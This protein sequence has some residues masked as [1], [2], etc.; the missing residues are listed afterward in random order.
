M[1]GFVV[2]AGFGVTYL[3][4]N[5]GYFSGPNE[6]GSTSFGNGTNM[7]P[8]GTNPKGVP[9]Y[10]YTDPNPLS[11]AVGANVNDPSVYGVSEARFDRHLKNGVAKQ[12]NVFFEKSFAKSWFASA[13][14]SAS[15]SRNLS[16]RNEV[17]QGMQNVPTSLLS[18]WRQ[19]YIAS[20]GTL[21]PMTQLIRN[22]LQPANGPLKP[23]TGAIGQ[24]TIQRYVAYLPYPYLFGGRIDN[25]LGFADYHAMQLRLSHAFAS[26]FQM[27]LNYTWSKELDYTSTAT[28]D[29]QGFNSGGTANAPDILNL[30]N[31]RKYGSA[32]SPHRFT[33]V[34]V[35]E[36]PFGPGKALAPS[37]KMLQHVIGNWQLGS[38]ITMQSGMPIVVSGAS[39][40]ALVGGPNRIPGVPIE[41][42][43]N[44]QKWYDGV[45]QVQLPCGR[46]ITPTKN[47]F[48]KYNACAFEG[49]TILAPNGRFIADQ[50]WVGTSAQSFGDMRTP[51]R[52]NFDLSLRRTFRIRESLTLNVN[53]D[54]TNL[55]NSAQYSGAYAGGLGATN[56]VDNPARGLKVG[57][58]STDTFGTI[59]LGTFDPRQVTLRLLVRF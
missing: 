15:V 23:F 8:Y 57:M 18:D 35:Y 29:G 16:N 43:E 19:Q 55:L 4:S 41:V 28:E 50:Y 56:L 49:Q 42:P 44:L 46:L 6:Y 26:G 45:T 48:L 5:T 40:G 53:A 52:T 1:P 12:W 31:N 10:R 21:N 3:P 17:F 58:G 24:A 14:Y 34:I 13:G 7:I 37:S 2:R 39:D 51:G 20:N 33:A 32:D 38:V 22:P 25:S 27:D 36:L 30:R 47:T 59:G 11:L 54:A 9:A